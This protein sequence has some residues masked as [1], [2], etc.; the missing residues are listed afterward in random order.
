[1]HMKNKS[2]K[3]LLFS[4][5]VQHH[6]NKLFTRLWKKQKCNS[7]ETY[8]ENMWVKS[9]VKLTQ[10]NTVDTFHTALPPKSWITSLCLK[11]VLDGSVAFVSQRYQNL[12]LFEHSKALRQSRLQNSLRHVNPW[13]KVYGP[14]VRELKSMPSSRQRSA[15]EGVALAES[16][17]KII[18]SNKI[19]QRNTLHSRQQRCKNSNDPYMFAYRCT[20]SAHPAQLFPMYEAS[21]NVVGTTLEKGILIQWCL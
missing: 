15:V 14:Q 18:N 7:S 11:K 12:S 19:W 21:R 20:S 10:N 6:T 8:D 9:R 17:V 5:I 13:A 1:M 3:I 2:F 16:L 4:T